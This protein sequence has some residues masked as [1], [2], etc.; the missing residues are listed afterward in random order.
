MNHNEARAD[1]SEQAQNDKAKQ[2]VLCVKGV[3]CT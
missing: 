2:Q 3:C 1:A